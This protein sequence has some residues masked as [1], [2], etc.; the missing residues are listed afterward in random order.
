MQYVQNPIDNYA[1]ST[2]S[3]YGYLCI[4]NIL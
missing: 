4:W 1:Q 3:W 2:A